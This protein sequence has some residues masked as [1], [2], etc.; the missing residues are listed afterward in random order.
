MHDYFPKVHEH[1]I[2]YTYIFCIFYLRNFTK[3]ATL[4]YL[5]TKMNWLDFEIKVKNI[6][7]GPFSLRRTLIV[8]VWIEFDVFIVLLVVLQFWAS[9]IKRSK[10]KV[11]KLDLLWLYTI[12]SKYL[13]KLTR[14][15]DI[16]NVTYYGY[17]VVFLIMHDFNLVIYC[18]SYIFQENLNLATFWPSSFWGFFQSGSFGSRGIK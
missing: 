12:S 14:C 9:E 6:L 17:C 7:L 13:I 3:F 2:L 11:M 1:H 16:V 5:G 18:K 8:I 4:V 15:F 10:V